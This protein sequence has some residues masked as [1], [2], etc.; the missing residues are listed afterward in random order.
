MKQKKMILA[1]AVIMALVFVSSVGVSADVTAGYR[2]YNN[3]DLLNP[4]T[5]VATLTDAFAYING[6]ANAD[7][8]LI[9]VTE[10]DLDVGSGAA[11]LNAAGATVCLT[12]N[13]ADHPCTLYQIEAG[14]RHINVTAGNLVLENII[15]DGNAT[16]GGIGMGNDAAIT[17]NTA[18]TVENCKAYQGGG[19]YCGGNGIL[20]LNDGATI[21]GCQSTNHS[22]GGSG[23]GVYSTGA[24]ILNEG[25]QI[26]GNTANGGKGGGVAMCYGDATL[27]MNG[28]EISNNEV[29]GYSS[30][31]SG[32][33]VFIYGILSKGSAAFMMY[34]GKITNNKAAIGAG[35]MVGG[36]NNTS[37]FTMYGGEISYNE[38]TYGESGYGCGGGIF[39]MAYG[40]YAFK[41]EGGKIC[42]NTARLGGGICAYDGNTIVIDHGDIYENETAVENGYACGGGIYATGKTAINNDVRIYHN[43]AENYGGGIYLYTGGSL[44]LNDDTSL[45]GNESMWGGGLYARGAVEMNDDT[46]I[47]DNR[48]T[49]QGGGV[50]LYNSADFKM[51]GGTITENNAGTYGGAVSVYGNSAA[52]KFTMDA[53]GAPQI[54]HNTANQAADDVYGN[55]ANATVT[56][57]PVADMRLPASVTA[58]GWYVDG[59]TA[60]YRDLTAAKTLYDSSLSSIT[61]TVFLTIGITYTVNFDAQ[62][63]TAVEPITDI[64]TGSTVSEPT[65][66][67]RAGYL[68][69][70]WYTDP[71][72]T[73][74]WD[75]ENDKV[76]RNITLY[77]GWSVHISDLNTKDH[78]AYIYGYPDGTVQPGG[79]ITR[80]ETATIIYRLLTAQRRDEVFTSANDFSDVTMN[81]WYNKAVSSMANGGYIYGY[82]DGSFCGNNAITRAEFVAMLVRF[83]GVE[84]VTTDFTDLTADHWAYHFIATAVVVG[85]IEGY[86][87]GSFMPD[88][89]IT[90]A[91]AMTIIN[92]VLARGIDNSS[93]IPT[94]TKVW[95]D[96]ESDAWYYYEVIE[97]TN[98]HTYTGT[99]PAED[100]TS[101]E[102]DY[103]YDIETY[104]RP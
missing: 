94:G 100:W 99:R 48:S 34:D 84:D 44:I 103:T 49:Y 69:Q 86:S 95:P 32:G 4:E 72:F 68:F 14:M 62:G 104:E 30:D 39:T 58:A 29:T 8:W 5:T 2:V 63:G 11:E 43:G 80:A 20:T 3:A 13:N 47:E 54:Y 55:G 81:L 1:I 41:M 90:R 50:F 76:T 70:C 73:D 59:E 53:L 51:N 75:F 52:C 36:Q 71:E 17:M 67:T 74:V 37:K 12:S 46:L 89:K 26:T 31:Y 98:D 61:D 56:L 38:G 21:S 92:R 78:F 24:V 87:D 77:A 64:P 66:P 93:D 16:G 91:E 57:I 83:I 33:G 6:T 97:A 18:A 82:E 45:C 9:K 40:D 28:G 96:N 42:N 65:A 23:A 60:R 35:V 102:I 19:I 25:S 101:L 27:T 88:Q 22:T 85:W 79:N 15:I 10:D 7:S